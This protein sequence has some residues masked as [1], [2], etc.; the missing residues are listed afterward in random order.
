MR[1]L[2]YVF[3]RQTRALRLQ[4]RREGLLLSFGVRE[5]EGKMRFGKEGIHFFLS[6]IEL[7]E[8]R[9]ILASPAPEKREMRVIHKQNNR[10]K[11]LSAKWEKGK[12]Q[13]LIFTLSVT[14]KDESGEPKKAQFGLS[15]GEAYVLA[16]A[17]DLVIEE[18]LTN[19]GAFPPQAGEDVQES[20]E[21]GDE[22]DE[23]ELPLI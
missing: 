6:P 7:G 11:T 8:L 19:A 14:Q 9:Y 20:P 2:R 15:L 12:D 13:T 10:T 21:L 3:W 18:T 1:N 16:R 17:V 4:N 23:G 22:G 5:G